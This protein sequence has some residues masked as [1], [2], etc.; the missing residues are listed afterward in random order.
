MSTAFVDVTETPSFVRHALGHQTSALGGLISGIMLGG[1]G[2]TLALAGGL[3]AAFHDASDPRRENLGLIG[4]SL[5]GVGLVM[6]V[7]GIV[8]GY[9]SRPELRPGATTQWAPSGP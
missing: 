1:V 7:V 2:F 3:L 9:S 6:S 5:G 4:G 8:L